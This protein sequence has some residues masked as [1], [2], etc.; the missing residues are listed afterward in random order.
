[1]RDYGRVYTRF[2]SSDEIRSLT[3]DGKLLALYLLTSEHTTL[4]GVIRLPDG[5]ASEDLKWVPERV[6]EGFRELFRIGFANRCETTKWVW[7]RKFLEWNAPEN[8]NQ[9]KAA[10]KIVT[11]IPVNCAWVSEFQ[12]VFAI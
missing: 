1:M 12:R 5:Y 8:P 4:V 11:Q 6:R 2:W 10:R 7:V 3:D 9:W